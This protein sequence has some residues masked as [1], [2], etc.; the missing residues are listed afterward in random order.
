MEIITEGKVRPPE[1]E[2]NA[3][4]TSGF[5]FYDH[6]RG[7][8][9][10]EATATVSEPRYWKITVN[11]E[12]CPTGAWGVCLA[13]GLAILGLPGEAG[14]SNYAVKNLKQVREGD[15]LVA[16]TPQEGS[17]TVGGVG[18]VTRGYDCEEGPFDHPWNGPVRRSVGVDWQAGACRIDDLVKEGRFRKGKIAR[19]LDE[20]LP[21]EFEAVEERVRVVGASGTAADSEAVRKPARR[22]RRA[23]EDAAPF[24]PISETEASLLAL[25]AP[26]EELAGLGSEVRAE[27]ATMTIDVPAPETMPLEVSLASTHIFDPS[28]EPPPL[29]Q[30]FVERALSETAPIFAMDEPVRPWTQPAPEAGS[31]S[32]AGREPAHRREARATPAPK[33][34]AESAAALRRSHEAHLLAS[35]GIT[36]TQP[37][38]LDFGLPTLGDDDLPQEEFGFEDEPLEA[39]GVEPYEVRVGTLGWTGIFRREVESGRPCSLLL[40][41]PQ[42]SFLN[43]AQAGTPLR[44]LPLFA[45][46]AIGAVAAPG[47][48]ALRSGATFVFQGRRAS[49][50]YAVEVRPRRRRMVLRTAAEAKH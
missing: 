36:P 9:M 11:P 24:T 26:R 10:A 30:F 41:G 35:F 46:F 19:V 22:R 18:R 21:E 8:T 25:M 38:V 45:L 5:F 40:R 31:R 32:A 6:R 39:T 12:D 15:W 1:M 43:M 23:L 20:I 37:E 48:E 7:Q 14:E 42:Y 47:K 34:L 33:S 44:G 17:Y 2:A 27:P 3:D 4:H 13:T 49:G 16:Y 50:D 29:P 28:A